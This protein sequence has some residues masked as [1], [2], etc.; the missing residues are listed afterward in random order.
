MIQLTEIPRRT[1]RRALRFEHTEV[2]LNHAEEDRW[3]LD[4]HRNPTPHLRPRSEITT[5][6]Y[7]PAGDAQALS[8]EL[9]AEYDVESMIY[10]STCHR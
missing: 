1:R 8:A 2:E 3:C 4:C 5:M 10:C 9:A 6:G 7:E